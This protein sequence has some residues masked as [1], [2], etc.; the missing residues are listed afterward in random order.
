MPREA[1]WEHLRSKARQPSIGQVV[2]LAM[3]PVGRDN[4]ILK[5]IL[6]KDYAPPV[7]NP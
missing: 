4:P 1:R 3:E 6:P 2:D 7:L 5:D